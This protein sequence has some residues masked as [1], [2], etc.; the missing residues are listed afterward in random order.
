MI[1]LFLELNVEEIQCTFVSIAGD[2]GCYQQNILAS[3]LASVGLLLTPEI[4]GALE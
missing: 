3:H 1:N 4:V 2:L